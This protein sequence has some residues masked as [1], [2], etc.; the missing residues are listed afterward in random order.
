LI[1]NKQQW[2]FYY[3]RLIV[4]IFTKSLID[5]FNNEDNIKLFFQVFFNNKKL[6]F[7]FLI[8]KVLIGFFLQKEKTISIQFFIYFILKD[9]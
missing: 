8:K 1:I 6:S 5:F 4:F 2:K 7:F 9:F 3:L